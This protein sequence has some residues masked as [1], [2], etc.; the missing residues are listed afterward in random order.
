MLHPIHLTL[1]FFW[2]LIMA[3][4]LL[5]LAADVEQHVV[6]RWQVRDVARRRERLSHLLGRVDPAHLDETVARDLERARDEAGGLGLTLGPNDAGLT[7]LVRLLHEEALA[8]GVLL[9]HLLVLNGLGELPA[10]GQVRD[11][12]VVEDE[13]EILGALRERVADLLGDGRALRQQLLGVVLGHHGLEHLVAERRQHAVVEI[14]AELAVNLRQL[15]L[16]G[17]REHAQRDVHHLQVLRTSNGVD[18]ARRRAHV[19]DNGNL[20]ERDHRV[21]ALLVRLLHD[22]LKAIEDHRTVAARHIKEAR[23]HPDAADDRGRAQARRQ[24]NKTLHGVSLRARGVAARTA[25]AD[26]LMGS[27]LEKGDCVAA[28]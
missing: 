10:E 3:L 14:H 7:L 17:P 16:Q 18:H 4:G 1:F 22:T 11:G 26:T 21:R 6:V 27:A 8:L 9:S 25:A 19:H 2:F 24:A 12:H 28:S 15:V 23:V 20:Q 13:V 5:R